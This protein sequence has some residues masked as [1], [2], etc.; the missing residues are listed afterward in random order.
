MAERDI[1]TDID[2]ADSSA[3]VLSAGANSAAKGMAISR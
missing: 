2:M 1:S 3:Y